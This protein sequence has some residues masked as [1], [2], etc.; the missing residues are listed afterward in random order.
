MLVGGEGRRPW[1]TVVGIGADGLGGLGEAARRA[2]AAAEVPGGGAGQ[3]AMV[4]EAG[5]PRVLW[6]SPLAATLGEIEGHRGRTVVVLASGDPL[7]YGVGRLLVRRFG[8]AEVRVLPHVS[9][10]QLAAARLGWALEEVVCLSVHGRPLAGLARHLAPGRRL[11]ALTEDRGRSEERRVGK[12]GRT[13]WAAQ[14][15]TR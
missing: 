3:L 5:R 14:Q 10:F 4:A 12:E 13:R 7:W 8:A 2:V 9:A 11:L 1:L 15:Y 6:G